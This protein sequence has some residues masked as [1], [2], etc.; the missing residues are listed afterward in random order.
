MFTTKL[1]VSSAASK[2]P[3]LDSEPEQCN[4]NLNVLISLQLSQ[5]KSIVE[6]DEMSVQRTVIS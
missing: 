5:D 1:H 4:N 3:Q 2:N 6:S